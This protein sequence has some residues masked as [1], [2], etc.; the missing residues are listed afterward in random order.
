MKCEALKVRNAP[1]GEWIYTTA[2]KDGAAARIYYSAAEIAVHTVAGELN[3]GRESCR[4]LISIV[5][6][7]T[8]QRRF[9]V[10]FW[11]FGLIALCCVALA[12]QAVGL[13]ITVVTPATYEAVEL[14]TIFEEPNPYYVDRAYVINLVPDEVLE[15]IADKEAYWI[16]TGNDDKHNAD[17]NQLTFEVDANVWVYLAY[18]RR[19]VTPPDWV[20]EGFE[21]MEVD[22]VTTDIPLGVWKSIEEFPAGLVQLHGNDFGGGA[23]AG[24]NYAAFVV[25]GS[26]QAVVAPGKLATTWGQL[27]K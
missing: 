21:D 13:E 15:E 26:P 9:I 10:R 16:K 17:E 24:S 27:K 1:A 19:A 4:T 8:L 2:T 22:L 25:M 11:L 6:A 20:T 12:A 7:P 18:D 3:V 23:G 5:C 14:S